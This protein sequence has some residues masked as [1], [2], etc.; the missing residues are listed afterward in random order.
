MDR[1]IVTLKRHFEF[2]LIDTAPVLA[3]ADTRV[4]ASKADAV[5]MLTQWRRTSL[6]R[7]GLGLDLLI[8][9]GSNVVGIALT[10]VDLREQ[11][12]QGCGDRYYTSRATPA[13]TRN[14]PFDLRSSLTLGRAA[15]NASPLLRSGGK[16]GHEH[17]GSA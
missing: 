4:I 13:T 2:V 1:L 15:G 6:P 10:Q 9:T 11:S 12:M 14:R 16:R 8:E 3:V 5:L 7:R 17:F